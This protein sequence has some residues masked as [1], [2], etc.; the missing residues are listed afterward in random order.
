[1]GLRYDTT[2]KHFVSGETGQVIQPW[3]GAQVTTKQIEIYE[4][5][6][7]SDDNPELATKMNISSTDLAIYFIPS[8]QSGNYKAAEDVCD[9]ALLD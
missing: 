4:E 5:F 9:T 6:K 7:N 1:M 3:Y 8:Y 2:K